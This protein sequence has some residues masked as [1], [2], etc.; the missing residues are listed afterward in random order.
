M[1]SKILAQLKAKFPGVQNTLLDRVAETISKTVTKEEDID[2]AVTAATPFV[3]EFSAFHQSEADRR[4]T[5]A[6]QKREGELNAEIEKLKKAKPDDKDKDKP[7]PDDPPAWAQALIDQNK[8]LT[9]KLTAFETGNHQK[10][11][12]GKLTAKL[13]EAK[14]PEKYYAP[15]IAGRTF[16]DD[17]EVESF[18]QSI[19]TAH[20][21]FTQELVN[22]GLGQNQKPIL[23]AT[24]KDGVST[25]VQ[26]Y[27]A[28]KSTSDQTA[29]SGLGGKKI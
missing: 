17:A 25:G 24:N 19:V 4:V 10:T 15:M 14:V 27:I 8:S 23:G 6:V 16:K 2:A 3:T 26:D 12:T 9:E 13:T 21:D 5:E 7:K 11:L 28:S 20:Q 29:N 18:A 22:Q 1:K